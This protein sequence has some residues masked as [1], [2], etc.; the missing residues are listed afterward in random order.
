VVFAVAEPEAFVA[1]NVYVVVAVGLTFV[2]PLANADVNAPG[3]MAILV[4]PLVAQLNV[5]LE[6][7][8]T[9][10]G[11]AVK[12]LIVGAVGVLPVLTVIVAVNVAVS[13]LFVAVKV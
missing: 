2:D 5:L 1:V 3:V 6:P 7:E 12:E 11:F 4:A 13:E 9:V 8:L 10:A